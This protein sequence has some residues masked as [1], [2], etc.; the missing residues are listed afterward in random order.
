MTNKSMLKNSNQSHEAHVRAGKISAAKRGKASLRQAGQK[1]GKA[2]KSS[3][4]R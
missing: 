1:G 3:P 4:T 2:R